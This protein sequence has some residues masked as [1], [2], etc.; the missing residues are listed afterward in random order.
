MQGITKHFPPFNFHEVN[1]ND[2]NNIAIPLTEA[3]TLMLKELYRLG[4]RSEE[5][6]K[7]IN[8]LKQKQA[9][10]QKSHNKGIN[11]QSMSFKSQIASIDIQLRSYVDQQTDSAKDQMKM[12]V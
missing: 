7:S 3:V 10:N 4:L 11:D 9:E 12:T 6:T 5:H 1:P 8:T 2:W